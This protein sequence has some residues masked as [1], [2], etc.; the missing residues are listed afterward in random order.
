MPRRANG[1]KPARFH[2]YRTYAF[3]NKDPVIAKVQALQEGEGMRMGDA[4]LIAG[5]SP[6]TPNNWRRADGVRRPQF[7]S[8]AAY[9]AALGYDIEFKRRRVKTDVEAELA[10]AAKEREAKKADPD[11]RPRVKEYEFT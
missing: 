3:A 8:I 11:Y 4:A 6:T 9:V 2:L 10:K 7:A 1:H 5:I